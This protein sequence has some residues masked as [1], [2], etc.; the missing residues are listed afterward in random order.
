MTAGR[1]EAET[2]ELAII[3]A[4]AAGT[5]VAHR[6][7]V[8]RPDWSVVLFERTERIG[9]RLRSMRIPGLDH[10]IELGGMR[11]LTT[12]R[13]VSEVVARFHIP[14][15][16]FDPTGGAE[17]S[18]L[19]GRFGAGAG[20]PAA[21]DGYDL[22][23][24]ER[25]RSALDL[26][27]GAFERI[28]PG[29]ARLDDA[30]WAGVRASS[31]YLGRPLADWSIGEAISTILSPRGHQFVADAFGYDSGLR[32]FNVVD[33]I[34]YLLGGGNPIAE[35]RTP[36]DGMDAVPRAMARAF[37][38]AGGSIRLGHELTGHEVIDGSQ[39]LRFANGLTVTT[40]RVV[41]TGALPALRLLAGSS[42]AMATPLLARALASAEAFPAAKLY[43][44]YDRPWWR[45]RARTIRTTT[46]L[47]LRKLFYFDS[48]SDGP[49][50]LLAMYTDGLHTHPWRELADGSAQGSPAPARMLAAIEPDLRRIHPASDGQPPPTGSAFILWGDDPHETGWTFWSVGARSDD[51]I[52]D[53]I[54]PIPGLEL[55]ICGEAFSRAQAWVEGALETAET[56]VEAVLA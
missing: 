32:P 43:L 27:L 25:G 10:P 35:A 49:A 47:P 28:V 53:L 17:R 44:W 13:R 11:F 55:F 33:A 15:H 52:R 40:R 24:D 12:H 56:V 54:R 50:A 31:E 38:D 21:G 8:A 6:V 23:E 48:G 4:G 14:T 29:A 9:G 20:D 37:T 42:K 46:D 51:V 34:P 5:F 18:Y 41:F 26:L 36:N 1:S 45:D 22:P 39:R 7:K 16:P 2:V 19:R 3:G 30:G